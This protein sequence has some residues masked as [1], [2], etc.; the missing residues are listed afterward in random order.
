M[1]G[2]QG[3]EVL[4]TAPPFPDNRQHAEGLHVADA[5]IEAVWRVHIAPPELIGQSWVNADFRILSETPGSSTSH[6]RL[7]YHQ[8]RASC[9]KLPVLTVRRWG[10]TARDRSAVPYRQHAT[11]HDAIPVT[12]CISIWFQSRRDQQCPRSTTMPRGDLSAYGIGNR[13][14]WWNQYKEVDVIRLYI[15]RQHFHTVLVGNNMKQMLSRALY[16]FSKYAA[17]ID[18]APHQMIGC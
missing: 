17:T 14:G 11:G 12:Q 13:Q 6:W 9:V 3:H 16:G 4:P 10:E 8:P 1:E 18:R 2:R 5:V 7:T 15:D